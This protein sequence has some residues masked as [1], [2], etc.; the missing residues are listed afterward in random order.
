M[1]ETIRQEEF[2]ARFVAHMMTYSLN[3][4]GT[5]T[6]LRAYAEEV[7]PAYWRDPDQRSDGPEACAEADI[8]YWEED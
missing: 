8:S 6:E 1:T 3:F 7:A 2:C 5:E 4:G